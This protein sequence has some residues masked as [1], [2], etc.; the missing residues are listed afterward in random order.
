MCSHCFPRGCVQTRPHCA[1]FR[2]QY[3]GLIWRWRLA[4]RCKSG[5]DGEGLLGA[6]G[7]NQLAIAM[8]IASKAI[9]SETNIG[10]RCVRD[11]AT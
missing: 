7:V 3:K 8:A 9:V 5:A 10:H 4:G 11:R 2:K 1:L 6:S